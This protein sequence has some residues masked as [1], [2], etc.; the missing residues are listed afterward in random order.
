MEEQPGLSS[1]YRKSS[2]W[3]MFVA[4]GLVLS[5]FGVFMAGPFVP[6]AVGGVLLLEASVVGIL[7]ES[8]YAQ[9]TW[10]PAVALGSV[11]AATGAVLVQLTSY[12]TR[13][14]SL[15]G[16]GAIAVVAGVVLFLVETKR[17]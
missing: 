10:R 14:L 17:L 1:Q 6:V 2:P 4:L 9:T 13:G 5:E 8:N 16:A 11:F 12:D 7:R 15:V 3:P